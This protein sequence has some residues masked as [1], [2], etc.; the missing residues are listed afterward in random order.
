MQCLHTNEPLV[1]SVCSGRVTACIFRTDVS[2]SLVLL[3]RLV[4]SVC[5]GRVTACTFRT[6]VSQSLVLFL[7][8]FADLCG[9]F[10]G[11]WLNRIISTAVL[12]HKPTYR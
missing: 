5:S 7:F 1:R 6:D 9:L 10:Q 8:V 2:Q 3:N 11:H 4:R 12:S